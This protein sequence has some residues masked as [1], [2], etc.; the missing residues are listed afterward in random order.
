M[1][2]K[3]IHIS[4][5]RIAI[6]ILSIVVCAAFLLTFAPRHTTQ[7]GYE[8]QPDKP[9]RYSTLIAEFDFPVLRSEVEQQ[10]MR[11]SIRLAYQPYYQLQTG[12]G[13]QQIALFKQDIAAGKYPD[14]PKGGLLFAEN[15]L[16]RIYAQG[17][18][19]VKDYGEVKV[20][21]PNGIRIV[22]AQRA[23]TREIDEVLTTRT[24]YES[25]MA[26]DSLHRWG[27]DL[28]K[29]NLNTYLQ[30]NL[31][32]DERRNN[33]ALDEAFASIGQFST[34]V[35]GGQ[36][37]I[38]QGDIVTPEM[39][40]ILDSLKDAYDKRQ[41]EHHS[42]WWVLLGQ[43]LF[44]SLVFTALFSYIYLFRRDYM[45]R[46]NVLCLLFVLN[47]SLPLIAYFVAAHT[48]LSVYLIPFAI[49]PMFV[50][51]FLD[52]RTS[53]VVTLV[54]AL[55]ASLVAADQYEFLLVQIIVGF[56]T[57]YSLKEVT[58]RSQVLRVAFFNILAAWFVCFSLDLV[59]GLTFGSWEDV[60]RFDYHRYV[61]LAISGGLQ[62]LAYPLMYLVE[63]IFGFTSSVTLIELMNFNE[64]LLSRMSREAKGTFNHTIQV[65]NLAAEVARAIGAKPLL[66]RVGALYHDIGKLENPVF[67]TE[68]QSGVNPH[69]NLD[70]MSSAR[71]II[72]HVNNGLKLAEE[73]SLPEVVREFITTHH[74]K[75]MA[76]YF[77]IQWQNKHPEE[78][79]D[80]EAFT[81][82]GHYPY[83]AEQAAL[84]MCDAVEAASRSLKEYTEESISNLVNKI[85]DTQL[86]E[87]CYNNCPI[88]FEDINLAK[89]T[90]I[91]SLMRAYHT[92]IAYP[93][94]K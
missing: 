61:D 49:V 68:N 45:E 6:V 27:T 42:D 55:L 70:E 3:Q 69:D 76:K 15:Q 37:I 50:R 91:E 80:P 7:F 89:Q 4:R 29:C 8:Y 82:P 72:D 44:A 20:A 48:S 16:R 79:F 56:N 62:L 26:A 92:R 77:A 67:F 33:A 43:F 78:T 36:K 10:Q 22:S 38:S 18:L 41:G 65:S 51:I 32:Y 12:L 1:A 11:D 19:S 2:K 34:M 25:I 71:I 60:L 23:I 24:A 17:F 74:G 86:R 63:R 47:T 84:M 28:Q 94:L 59:R 35:Q 39:V 85:I 57:I 66:A 88:T 81:Y 31:S 87:G 9:W 52:T 53:L 21:H 83:T 13:E 46:N 30:P 75:G 73:H 90:L 40:S 5:S 58:E 93:E 14:V 54:V 64:G